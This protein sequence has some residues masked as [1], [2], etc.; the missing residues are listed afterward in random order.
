MAKH[1]LL[2]GIDSYD[3]L[4]EPENCVEDACAMCDVL[5]TNQ[6]G[7]R[8]Y[9]CHLL[10]G[11]KNPPPVKRYL[12]R[13]K[14]KELFGG[15]GDHVLF[16]FSGHGVTTEDGGYLVTQE[17]TRDDPGL[18]MDALLRLANKSRAKS[19]LLILDCCHSGHLGSPLIL[20]GSDEF[21]NYAYIREGLTIL[22]ASRPS[23]TASSA[24]EHGVFTKLILGALS[25]GAADVR[26]RVSAAAIYAYVEQALSFW[27]Q[28]PLYKSNAD[29]LPPVRLCKPDVPDALLLEL[30]V[31]FETPDSKFHMAPSYEWSRRK[32]AKKE[33]VAL[34]D[35]FKVLR[36][37]RLLTTEDQKD[38]YFI[39]LES[40][41][42]KLTPLG[43]FYW[44]LAKRKR[45]GP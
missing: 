28:R 18:S 34:F 16:Y 31:I 11:T 5:A 2:V 35:K 40:G 36:N 42:V 43:Q 17:G 4:E 41:W 9:D 19:V 24:G 21:Q 37:A 1:A 39:A 6:D 7:S 14:L 20:Q 13:E 8:N 29:H 15:K 3:T 25:G 45:L 32:V 10:V 30:P 27:E 23:E 38:L 12:L 33:H 44:D 22:A 26:G